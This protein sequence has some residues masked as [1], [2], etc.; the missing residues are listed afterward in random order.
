MMLAPTAPAWTESGTAMLSISAP[1]VSSG[2]ISPK[3]N[4][5]VDSGGSAVEKQL[6]AAHQGVAGHD[7]QP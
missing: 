5:A 1:G 2:S 6:E 7:R 4:G 3:V